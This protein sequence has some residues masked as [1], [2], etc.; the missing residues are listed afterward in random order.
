MK[1]L[2]IPILLAGLLCIPAVSN[3][4][5]SVVSSGKDAKVSPVKPAVSK[6]VVVKGNTVH[7]SVSGKASVVKNKVKG[8]LI[9][10]GKK[11]NLKFKVMATLIGYRPGSPDPNLY[12]YN[13]TF[14][15]KGKTKLVITVKGKTVISRVF[16]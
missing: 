7:V 8:H 14:K 9:V 4:Q 16:K 13:T 2:V 11:V 6:R 1:K 12:S 5:P 10:K 3:A 15:V